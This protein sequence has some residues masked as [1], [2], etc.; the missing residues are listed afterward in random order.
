MAASWTRACAST[1]FRKSSGKIF[2]R[3]VWN[4]MGLSVGVARGGLGWLEVP[5]FTQHCSLQPSSRRIW[6]KVVPT[7]TMHL[8]MST[9]ILGQAGA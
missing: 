9:S 6:G 7:R 5:M 1:A 2:A 3:A 4:P 8:R